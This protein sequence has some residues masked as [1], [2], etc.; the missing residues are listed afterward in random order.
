MPIQPGKKRSRVSELKIM[1]EPIAEYLASEKK[2]E[3]DYE[4]RHPGEEV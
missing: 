2:E 1:N 3:K 4:Q